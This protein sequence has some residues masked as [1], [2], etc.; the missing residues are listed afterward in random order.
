MGS[1]APV[2][3]LGVDGGASSTRAA[4]ADLEGHVVAT[5]T[6]G[7]SNHV[8]GEAGLLRLRQALEGAVGT[9]LGRASAA[10][11]GDTL[12]GMQAATLGMTGVNPGSPEAQRVLDELLALFPE[13]AL[14]AGLRSRIEVVSDAR[15]ALEGA[16][17]GQAG[18]L[19]YAGTGSVAMGRDAEGVIAR[20]GGWGYLIDDEGGGYAIGRQALKAVYRARDGRGPRTR[21]A[22]LLLLHFGARDLDALVRIV[23]TDDGL[24]RPAVARL[25]RL[26]A[27]AAWEGDP[28]ALG[29]YEQAAGELA[30]LAVAVSEA[31]AMPGPVVYYSGGVFK[32][33]H[34]MVGAFG[35]AVRAALPGA[36]V[37]P[38]R[39]SPLVGALL[40][41]YRQMGHPATPS[42]LARLHSELEREGSG[43]IPG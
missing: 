1:S 16:T 26:V 10:P 33:G 34:P 22:E 7:P 37:A 3:V 18:I 17:E 35:E 20:A 15:T 24:D 29:I 5:G 43:I 9:A 2:W 28:V 23:Y 40:M 6:A 8:R 11:G 39:H 42:I 14:Q 25:A 31:L 12:E 19:V 13:T 36:S 21:L 41:A 32:A 27:L 30:A 4:I 38:A